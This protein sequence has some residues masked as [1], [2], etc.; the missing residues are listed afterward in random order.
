MS[1][2]RD[3]GR[4]GDGEKGRGERGDERAERKEREGTSRE[5]RAASREPRA[6]SREPRVAPGSLSRGT[7]LGA[8]HWVH[9]TGVPTAGTSNGTSISASFN[10]L[11]KQ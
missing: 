3:E 6:A 9:S 5:P 1:E 2:A 11:V 4:E 8:L 10:D 7:P